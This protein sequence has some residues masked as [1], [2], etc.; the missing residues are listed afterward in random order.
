MNDSKLRDLFPIFSG[1]NS[2][3]DWVYLDSAATS[4]K[5]ATVIDAVH[6]YYLRQNASVHRSSHNLSQRTTALF[7]QTRTKVQH[8]INARQ[9]S[10]II[11]TKG[12][13]ESINLVASVLASYPFKQANRIVL[14]ASEHHANIVPWQQLAHKL[15]FHIDII[16]LTDQGVLD[17]DSGLELINSTCAILALAHV[18]NALGNINPVNA[19]IDKAKKHNVITLIDGAQATAHLKVDVQSLDCDFYVFSGHK[20]FAPAG[21]GV[22]YGRRKLLDALPPY[23]FGGEM[24]SHVS[25]RQSE[26][27]DLPFKYEAGTPNVEGVIGLASAIDFIDTHRQAICSQ[28]QSLYQYLLEKLKAIDGLI[29]YGDTEHSIATQSFSIAGYDNSDIGVLLNEQG[30]AIR[31]GHHCA[32]PLMK[33]LGIDGTL[34]VSLACYNHYDDIDALCKALIKAVEHLNHDQA[35]QDVHLP[36]T[37]ESKHHGPLAEKIIQ[38]KSWEQ[39]YRQI[40]LAGKNTKRFGEDQKQIAQEV[41]GCESQV[42]LICNV[43]NQQVTLKADS[44]SKIVRGLLAILFEPLETLT[45]QQ[46]SRYDAH[47]YFDELG[48]SKHLSVSRGNGINAV[49]TEIKACLS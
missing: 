15:N 1:Q 47:A 9:S 40:M 32:M 3:L 25:Y 42:W 4:Q 44:Q 38:S 30:I 17:L 35:S 19:L 31:V 16:P 21:I 49:L 18:S 20:M 26:F 14:S 27:Q 41:F 37:N 48:L 22:L 5:P 24:I 7:E 33:T 34:R 39:V 23:Q 46:I 2:D 12:A 29:L 13:T 28:E 11:W 10:E 8:F 45:R 6:G 36:Q 43:Q